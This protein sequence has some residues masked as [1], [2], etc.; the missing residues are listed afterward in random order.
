MQHITKSGTKWAFWVLG[1]LAVG[2]FVLAE[3]RAAVESNDKPFLSVQKRLISD[4]FD[5]GIR[6]GDRNSGNAGPIGWHRCRAA[7]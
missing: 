4:G 2:I 7:E 6:F 5:I 3:S 1:L